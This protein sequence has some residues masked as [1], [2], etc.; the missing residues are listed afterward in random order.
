MGLNPDEGA[1]FVSVY[2][3]DV[4]IF[5]ETLEVHLGHLK[6][7]M[8]RLRQAGLKLKPSK[9]HFVCEE[10]QYLGHVIAAQGT[11]PNRSSH[12]SARLPVPMSVKK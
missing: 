7:V 10:V 8:E 3:D 1:S 2:L 6:Q 9:C 12:R 5:S 4:I 11:K